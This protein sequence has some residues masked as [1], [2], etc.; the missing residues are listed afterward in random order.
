M[1]SIVTQ[2]R[3]GPPHS[4][5]QRLASVTAMPTG[6]GFGTSGAE[7]REAAA[8]E[9]MGKLEAPGLH[10]PEVVAAN[11]RLVTAHLGQ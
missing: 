7:A 5:C 2:A 4:Q 1:W 10:D 9:L 8:L 6:V 3:D 11:Q